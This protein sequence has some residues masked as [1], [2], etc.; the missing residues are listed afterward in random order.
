[1]KHLLPK[2][3]LTS[4]F[5]C[6][7]LSCSKDKDDGPETE[8]GFFPET[9]VLT[10]D[11][12]HS[13]TY[14]LTYDN[15][16]RFSQMDIS[17]SS[18]EETSLTHCHFSYNS[19]GL[20]T[21]VESKGGE[22]GLNN[23]MEFH[24]DDERIISGITYTLDT[25]LELSVGY[26]GGGANS[27]TVDGE[28]A[29]LPSSWNFDAEDQLEEAYFFGNS[30]GTVPAA[31][32]TGVFY[33]VPIQPAQQIWQGMLFYIVPHELYFFSTVE[34]DGF[35]IADDSYKYTAKERD[36]DGNLTAFTITPQIPTPTPIHCEV[37]Y[38]KR[39]L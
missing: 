28:L 9:I 21:Q 7:L 37:R 8:K 25:P 11:A 33:N 14:S 10:T 4:L 22:N 26:I 1:M 6:G 34:L 24:Y 15:Q 30:V 23:L 36:A 31:T 3:I 35:K 20:L 5:L 2:S 39:N 38:I 12:D 32:G 18:G 17:R 16:N 19:A 29:N 13:S 27:Y